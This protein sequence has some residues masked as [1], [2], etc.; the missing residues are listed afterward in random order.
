MGHNIVNQEEFKEESVNLI[1]E[2]EN[3]CLGEKSGITK[4]TGEE[5][6]AVTELPTETVTEKVLELKLICKPEFKRMSKLEK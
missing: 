2:A 4:T 3:D 5:N 6:V 1:E